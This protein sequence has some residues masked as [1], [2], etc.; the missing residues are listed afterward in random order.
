MIF[1]VGI[2][3]NNEG[4]SIAWALEHPGCYAYGMKASSA[5]NNL[6][7]A[8]EKY[9][10]WILHHESN[11]WLTFAQDDIEIVINGTWDCYFIDDELGKTDETEGYCVDS[12]FPHDWKPLTKIEIRHALDMLTWSRKDLLKAVHGLSEEKLN[13]TYAGERWSIQG[14][15]GHVG[16]AEWWY[17]DR[18][19]L[20]FPRA[21][22]PEE[23]VARLE[24]VRKQFNSA[25]YKLDGVK[26]VLGVDGE[27][28]SPRKMLRRALW[29]ER[30]HT[31][32][33]LK[34]LGKAG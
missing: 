21:D 27:F 29:H 17:L 34:L 11:T 5:I 8:L 20:A 23:P 19:G 13:Q 4:R 1:Q 6:E 9:A 28:W 26:Q 3:N 2:D 33:I 25:L 12:F 10:G 24:K 32:H 15:L 14:I 30:D 16:G 7:T 18:L 31:E 22:V